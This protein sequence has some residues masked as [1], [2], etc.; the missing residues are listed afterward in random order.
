MGTL[1]Q[2]LRY[3]ARILIK[4]PGFTA[5]AVLTIAL[6]IGANSAIFSVVNSVLLRPLSFREPERLIKI[7]ETF[8]PGG[9][10]SVSVPN[11]K[12]WREQNDVFT[13]IAAYQTAGFN[14][15]GE[16][17]P[18]RV[19]GATVSANFFE[20]LGV[21]PQFGRTF[22][23]GEDEPGKNR[24]VVLSHLLWQRNFGGE[25][26]II[27]EDILLGGENYQ[28]VGVMPQFFRFPSRLTELW[29]PLDIPPDYASR[30]N[31]FL[32][33]FG[34]LKPH[35][36]LEQAREQMVTIARRLE[37]QY[38]DNQAGRSVKLIPLQEELVQNVRLALLVLLGAVGFVLLIACVNVANL[39]LARGAAR[40]REVAIRTA[41]G[42]G[43]GRLIRQ[44]LTESVL[45]A[46]IG[47]VLGLG[48]G[49]LGVNLLVSLAISYLPRASEVSLDSRVVG[50]T[51]LLSVLTGII[52]GL[53]PAVQSARADVQ[54]ALKDGGNAGASSQQNL[55]RSALVV[56]EVSAAMV[57]LVGAGLLIKSF[58]RLQQMDAGL[59]PENIITLGINLPQAKYSTS[60]AMDNFYQQ[61]ID[62]VSSLP[63]V[64]AAGI[65]NLLPLQ[66]WGTN[67]DIHI[68]GDPPYPPGQA[69]LAEL[70]V[71]SPDYFRALGI[72]LIAGRFLNA[73]DQENSERVVLINQA[74]ARRYIPNKD[75][76]GKRLGRGDNTWMKIVGVVGDVRQSGLTQDARPE[77]YTP[78]AQTT[79]FKRN[80]SVVVRASSEP[81]SLISSIRREV[82]N[83]DP[84]QPIY[85]IK[86]ME[87]VISESISDR[88][89]NMLLLGIFAAVALI[90][91]VIGIYSVMSYVV[92]QSTREIG[93][94]MA[95]GAQAADVLKL[96]IGNGIVLALVGVGIGLGGAFALTRL[97]ASMLYGVT[98]TDPLTFLGVAVLLMVIAALACYL[99]ARRATKVHP[100]VALRCE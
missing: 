3:A 99:P 44:F 63:G 98:T 67:G 47:G 50:F 78:Y 28:V 72:P 48:L 25:P 64:Q 34:R 66:Q 29:V 30:G 97:M 86:S 38:P 22:Q 31:H 76:I 77:I 7:W 11:L 88:R 73:R 16:E 39:L 40:R 9:Q 5:V 32:L 58:L 18:E 41:L 23:S 53:V 51:L 52:F 17:S 68:E 84:N 65:I 6:G 100:M 62:R 12:D 94:R 36:S 70:R 55:L 74:L 83:V 24:I 27:G 93:I 1:W 10:G 54:S 75:P 82:R 91:A 33:T 59:R 37:Q 45:L 15:K 92:T 42:A 95:L 21:P 87:T 79:D 8:L 2:D 60:Q 90:L 20:V 56:A 69:P 57:L 61:L 85:N 89:L 13:Q 46:V 14:L 49:K 4:Q 81:T 71:V 26:G 80:V 96:V 35:V 19:V 43:R